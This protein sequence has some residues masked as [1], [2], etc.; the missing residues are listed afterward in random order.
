MTT[1]KQPMEL[2]FLDPLTGEEHQM[3]FGYLNGE[4]AAALFSG[5]P[6]KQT[7][8][9]IP[10]EAIL[11]ATEGWDEKECPVCEWGEAR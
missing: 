3:A 6:G 5:D 1:T 7:F 11:A 9:L 2:C 4:A 8:V 10:K